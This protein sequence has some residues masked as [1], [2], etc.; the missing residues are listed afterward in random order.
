[1]LSL[2]GDTGCSL[3]PTLAGLI[4]ASESGTAVLKNG[5]SIGMVFSLGANLLSVCFIGVKQ[6][7]Y[8]GKNGK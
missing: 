3:G 2:A 5:I 6:K 7:G 4:A 8:E 1:M